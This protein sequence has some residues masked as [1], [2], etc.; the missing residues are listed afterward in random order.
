MYQ[1]A[2]SPTPAKEGPKEQP[3]SPA[4][5]TRQRYNMGLPKGKGK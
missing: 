4:Q 2:K 3:P 1:V 5:P